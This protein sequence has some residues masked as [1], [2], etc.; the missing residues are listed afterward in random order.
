MMTTLLFIGNDKQTTDRLTETDL[1]ALPADIE[2][3][4]YD[5]TFFNLLEIEQVR[6]IINDKIDHIDREFSAFYAKR[7][8][9]QYYTQAYLIRSHYLKEE[10]IYWLKVGADKLIALYYFLD[11]HKKT[12]AFPE[13]IAIHTTEELIEK[14]SAPLHR[15]LST[16]MHFI[17]KLTEIAT[18]HKH[19]SITCDIEEPHL[20]VYLKSDKQLSQKINRKASP[21]EKTISYMKNNFDIQIIKISDLLAPYN[22][23]Y[24]DICKKIR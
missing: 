23:F 16:H 20:T 8:S 9:E 13:E 4:T 21:T 24:Q 10:L 17:K 18:A 15:E 2:P 1:I 22:L 12:G 19:A 11:I 6:R 3:H 7:E 5:H 14:K